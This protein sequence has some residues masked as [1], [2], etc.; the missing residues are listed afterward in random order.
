MAV[1]KKIISV[2]KK[3]AQG[4]TYYMTTALVNGDEVTGWSKH[5]DDYEVGESVEVFYHDKYDRPKMR[6]K[7]LTSSQ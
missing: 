7:G 3:Q 6:K 2:E 1:I 4:D 5:F